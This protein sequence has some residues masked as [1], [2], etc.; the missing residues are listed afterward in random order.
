MKRRIRF[1]LMI[2]AAFVVAIGVWQVWFAGCEFDRRV[3]DEDLKATQ[4]ARQKM[5]DRLIA[6]R[7]LQGMTRAEVVELLGEP[8]WPG[9]FLPESGWSLAYRLG[10]DRGFLSFSF[11]AEW[12][13]VR[14]GADG[15]VAEYRL[16]ID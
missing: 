5:A 6:R 2:A 3:W 1:T 14:L 12:L 4:G 11:D 9:Y 8:D 13:V 16:V 15:R 10:P 7:V